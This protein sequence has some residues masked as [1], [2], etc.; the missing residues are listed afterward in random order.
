MAVTALVFVNTRTGAISFRPPPRDNNCV[1][2]IYLSKVRARSFSRFCPL[3]FVTKRQHPVA[4]RHRIH[5]CIVNHSLTRLLG[6]RFLTIGSQM[7]RICPVRSIR[8]FVP[9]RFVCVHDRVHGLDPIRINIAIKIIHFIVCDSLYPKSRSFLL[10]PLMIIDRTPSFSLW[11]RSCNRR[12]H[13]LLGLWDLLF[14][15]YRFY[16]FRGLCCV[17]L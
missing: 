13:R 5:L 8:S 7:I 6:W 10:I 15:I 2:S 9:M 17:M 14:P 1:E 3:G 11:P 4:I 12:F 16:S